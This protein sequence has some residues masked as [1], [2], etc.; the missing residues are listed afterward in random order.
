MYRCT[1]E[2][3]LKYVCTI[4]T[5]MNRIYI[6]KHISKYSLRAGERAQRLRALTALPE[7]VP[8]SQ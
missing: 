5:E 1:Y 2:Y 3:I 6:Y 8:E 4:H 7:V